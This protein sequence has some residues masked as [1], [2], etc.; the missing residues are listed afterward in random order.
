MNKVGIILTPDNRSKA[1]L[2]KIIS[3]NIVLDEI[4]FMNDNR[5]VTSFT[6]DELTESIKCNFNLSNNFKDILIKNN[7]VFKEF[8]FVNINHPE[9]ILYL[10]NSSIDYFIFSGG[11]ILKRDILTCGP[12]FIHIHPGMVPEYRGSTCFYYSLINQN[13]SG[14]TAFVMDENLDTGKIVYQKIFNKPNHQYLDSVYDPHIRSETLV[15]I[16]KLNLLNIEDFKNQDKYSG[17]TYF[18]IHPVLNHI[19]ILGCL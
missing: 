7:M 1:Y 8:N 6:K 13:N 12:K 10:K 3:N 16:L 5:K 15:D 2:S 11:G 18:I 17:N 14:V 4:I 19:S 9:L